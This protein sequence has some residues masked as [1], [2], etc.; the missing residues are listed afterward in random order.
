MSN[1]ILSVLVGLALL[2]SANP[3]VAM[4]ERNPADLNTPGTQR[5][6]TLPTAAVDHSSVISLGSAVDP[7]TGK[8]VEGYA[9]VHYAKGGNGGGGKPGGALYAFLARGAKWKSVEPWLMNPANA[10]NLNGTTLFNNTAA[11]IS[12]WEDATDGIL[13]NGISGNILG[14]GTETSAQLSADTV[15]PDELNEVY[16]ADVSESGA[17]AI[18]IVWGIFGGPPQGRELVEWDQ[19]YDD[20]DYDWSAS[21]EAGKMDFENIATH[22][23]GHSIGLADLYNL[24][25]L[26]QTMYGYADYGETNKQTLESGD[27]AGTNALY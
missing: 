13:G 26:E 25:A 2:L 23:L 27:I 15:S 19:V 21:G 14:D 17:I 24:E 8:M 11:D 16:F 3:V 20:V 5:T 10:S 18:T 22:E 6:L 9:I 1:K 4:A 7:Q 12:K